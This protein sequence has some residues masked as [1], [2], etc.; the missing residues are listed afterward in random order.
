MSLSQEL[1]TTLIGSVE[2]DIMA[3]Q[4]CVVVTGAA[5]RLGGG[6]CKLL[7]ARPGW[8][9]IGTD[10]APSPPEWLRDLPCPFYPGLDLVSWL[11]VDWTVD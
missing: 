7:C 5:G 9:V 3:E 2:N 11:I 6:V 8:V 1:H 10:I 4:P